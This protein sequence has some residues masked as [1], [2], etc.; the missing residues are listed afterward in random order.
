[1]GS[2]SLSGRRSAN[3]DTTNGGEIAQIKV[4]TEKHR[5]AELDG[6]SDEKQM[7]PV[8]ETTLPP[9]SA[10]FRSADCSD[11]VWFKKDNQ[12]RGVATITSLMFDDPAGPVLWI[13]LFGTTVESQME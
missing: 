1:M 10:Y 9:Q 11:S 5:Y 8:T 2:T 3:I 12:L 4:W 13:P 7:T 6:G